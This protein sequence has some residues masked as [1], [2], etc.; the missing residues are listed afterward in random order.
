MGQRQA[1]SKGLRDNV[2]SRT[3]SAVVWLRIFDRINSALQVVVRHG[4]R[5]AESPEALPPLAASNCL[6]VAIASPVPDYA[7]G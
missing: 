4:F 6:K 5:R 1:S 7:C 3:C 2:Q